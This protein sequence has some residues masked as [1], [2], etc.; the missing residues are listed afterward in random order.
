[1]K[2]RRNEFALDYIAETIFAFE[3]LLNKESRDDQEMLWAYGVLKEYFRVT[4][5]SKKI[6]PY[7]RRF[8]SIVDAHQTP[9]ASTESN[10]TDKIPYPQNEAAKSA[11]NCDE[12]EK[13]YQQRRSIR[14]YTDEPVEETLIER[15][16]RMAAWAPS[17]CNRQAFEFYYIANSDF[18]SEVVS[19]PMGTKGFSHQV[20]NL[21]IVVGDL[22]AYP[23][24]RDRHLIYID[25]S[26]AAMQFMLAL[27][28]QG[29][30]SCPINWPDV[31]KLEKRMEKILDL[32]AHQRPVMLIS[33]G[34]ADPGG[35]VPFS[36][37]KNILR[38]ID[39]AHNRG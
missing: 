19:I 36:Q 37:K 4:K 9:V 2:P 13:L 20:K 33:I 14:W 1:M 32:G 39:G 10:A 35:G 23:S 28:A 27:E 8:E 22:S 5:T 34:H 15:A 29:L 12:L 6:E 25:G 21:V 7:L 30:S 18:A 24:E 26:L 17:A 16:A 38:K 3:A 11:I 31:E